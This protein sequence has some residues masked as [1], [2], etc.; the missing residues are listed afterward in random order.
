[1]DDNFFADGRRSE[2]TKR[3][4]RILE[5][6]HSIAVA[7]RRYS[8]KDLADRF[9]ISERRIQ[10]DLQ[11]IRHNLKLSLLHDGEHYY[12]EHL[13]HLPTTAYSFTEA[14]A[15]IMALR[16]AQAIPGVNS[17]ELVA[18]IARLEAVFPAEFQPMLRQAT[19]KLPS[20]AEK[21]HR[22]EMLTLLHRALIEHR[23]LRIAY[24]TG[25]REGE[26]SERTIEPYHIMPYGR[27]WQVIAFDHK[28]GEPREFKAD[29]IQE[30]RLLDTRYVVPADFDVSAY[31]GDA[32][33]FMRGAASAP[34]TVVLLFEPEAGRWVAEETWHHSQQTEILAGGQI[35]LTLTVGI[36]PEMV[37]WLLYYGSRVQVLEPT[38]LQERVVEEHQ[39]AA[40]SYRYTAATTPPEVC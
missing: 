36:T 34:E 13:P 17:S 27:S 16:I 4:G 30:G 40:E 20:Q 22:Q 7:P 19:E 2:E 37:N 21:S 5:M 32:W 8:R 26:V 31:L 1:M 29:R 15:L 28:R 10:S 25:S 6:V 9:Q 14:V 35:Q 38:W 18:A 23:Q 3:A 12:F 33:G 39:R 11:L 24:A